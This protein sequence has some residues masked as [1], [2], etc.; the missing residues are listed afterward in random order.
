MKKKPHKQ[1]DLFTK[2]KPEPEQPFITAKDVCRIFKGKVITD[3]EAKE[4]VKL[5]EMERRG[6]S[7]EELINET[8][9]KGV[10]WF[11]APSKERTKW[12]KEIFTEDRKRKHKG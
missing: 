11:V 8:R 7:G 5:A 3:K 2:F 9:K 1:G 6:Q 12:Y 4:E 10:Y